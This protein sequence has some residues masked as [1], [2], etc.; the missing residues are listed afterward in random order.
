MI[1]K[2]E[3]YKIFSEIYCSIMPAPLELFFGDG[4]RS[5]TIYLACATGLK[6]VQTWSYYKGQ[7][8]SWSLSYS[9]L[10]YNTRPYLCDL[11]KIMNLLRKVITC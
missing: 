7:I 6:Q 11:T 3:S 5:G 8:C 9:L 10:L 2:V 4:C 1:I